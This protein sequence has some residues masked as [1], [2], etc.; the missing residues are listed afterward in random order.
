MRPRGA[1]PREAALAVRAA[2][3]PANHAN[4]LMRRQPCQSAIALDTVQGVSPSCVTGSTAPAI[5]VFDG[6]GGVWAPAIDVDRGKH[7]LIVRADIRGVKPADVKIEVQGGMLTLRVG[8]TSA[9][10]SRSRLLHRPLPETLARG[11]GPSSRALALDTC[12]AQSLRRG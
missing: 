2:A 11:V 10:R 4:R 1:R 12:D 6:K 8:K 7:E 3:E 9:A 5:S